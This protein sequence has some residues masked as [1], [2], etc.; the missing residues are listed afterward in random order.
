M[1][2][3]WPCNPL[4]TATFCGINLAM[5]PAWASEDYT[6][7]EEQQLWSYATSHKRSYEVDSD[8]DESQDWHPRTPTLM[9][10]YGAAM[11]VDYFKH[12]H[13][14]HGRRQPVHPA[15]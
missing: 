1:W 11:P 4:A 15:S 6:A 9:P 5:M 8:S 3:T 10:E 7:I 2:A 12:R 13:R 14:E